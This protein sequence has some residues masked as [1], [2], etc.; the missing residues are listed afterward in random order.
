MERVQLLWVAQGHTLPGS[1]VKNHRHP[2]FHMLYIT[3]GQGKFLVEGEEYTLTPGQCLLIPKGGDHAYT[4]PN[5]DIMEYLEVKFSL[6]QNSL[7]TALS[8][9][10]TI[11]SD[12]GLV[13]PLIHQILQEYSDLGSVADESAV[14]YLVTILNLLCQDVRYRKKPKSRFIDASDFSSL[15]Q[16]IIR[17]LEENYATDVSLDAL[18]DSL[19]YNKSYLCVAFK[20]DTGMTILDCLNT[21]R[22]RRAAELIVYS[23][24]SI[25]QV[26]SQCGFASVSHFNRVFLK[27]VGTTPGQCRRAHPGDIM[28]EDPEKGK[29]LHAIP[30][31]FIYSVLAHK[32][33]PVETAAQIDATKNDPS[34]E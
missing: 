34:E 4:N 5:E 19:D 7:D 11:V 32:Q 21:V 20:K 22:I 31:R 1:G 10:G 6:G 14:S 15:S 2:Y 9:T 18:A 26:A 8:K 24:H 3:A 23:D 33:I 13:G 25:A 27:Y 16:K 30:N 28:F 29:A 12:T 17:Y